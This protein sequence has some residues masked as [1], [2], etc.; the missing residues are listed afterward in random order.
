MIT[1]LMLAYPGTSFVY[2]HL[3]FTVNMGHITEI[4]D[5]YWDK[6]EDKLP[7][8]LTNTDRIRNVKIILRSIH[9]CVD[10]SLIDAGLVEWKEVKK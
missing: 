5:K 8:S 2:E 1:P 6:R 10:Q 4:S 7:L 9:I 3:P